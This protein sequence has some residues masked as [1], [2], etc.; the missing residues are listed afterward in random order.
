MKLQHFILASLLSF[1]LISCDLNTP[2]GEHTPFFDVAGFQI[3]NGDT[4]LLNLRG[5][6]L[7][8]ISVGDT[9]LFLTLAES[10]SSPLK[11]K[12]I[13]ATP[14]RSGNLV[15]PPAESWSRV[16]DIEKSVYDNS[17]GKF[18]VNDDIY[19]FTFVFKYIARYAERNQTLTFTL[20][21]NDSERF[22]TTVRTIRT[23][24]RASSG[25]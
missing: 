1:A 17:E 4:I 21:N 20:T 10:I 16:F 2:P 8:T 5:D 24:I 23:P 9:I 25:S 19:G 7:D 15:W 11:E 13:T 18:V 3:L 14:E 22:N 6:V 12:R